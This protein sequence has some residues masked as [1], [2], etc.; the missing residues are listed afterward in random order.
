MERSKRFFYCD[1]VYS[2]YPVEDLVKVAESG[3][4]ETAFSDYKNELGYCDD[5]ITIEDFI[6][7]M[8]N[9]TIRYCE[10]EDGIFFCK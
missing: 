7:G 8:K 10:N 5:N 6:S 2:T 1:E 3:D 4:Y 9:A